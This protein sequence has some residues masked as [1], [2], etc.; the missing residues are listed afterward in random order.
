MK[1]W[2]LLCWRMCAGLQSAS[3]SPCLSLGERWLGHLE[4][5]EWVVGLGHCEHTHRKG[6]FIL[7]QVSQEGTV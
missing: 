1:Y 3:A 4:V 2:I 5:S 7:L 6:R